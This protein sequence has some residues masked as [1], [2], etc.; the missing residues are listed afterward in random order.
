MWYMGFA[1]AAN[2]RSMATLAGSCP[3]E[4]FEAGRAFQ[5]VTS[6]EIR[7]HD[8]N[9]VGGGLLFLGRSIMCQIFNLAF[10]DS[11]YQAIQCASTGRCILKNFEGGMVVTQGPFNAIELA[12]NTADALE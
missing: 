2:C 3:E 9:E 1:I 5:T 7:P 10:N 12:A 11:G 8:I 4:N 6:T